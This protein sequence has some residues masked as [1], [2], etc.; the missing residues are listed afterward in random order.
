VKS[1]ARTTSKLMREPLVHFVL[2][3]AALFALDSWRGTPAVEA[4]ELR[5]SAGEID[6]LAEVFA[7][8]WMRPPTGA[9]LED[10]IREHLREEVAYREALTLG[11]DRDDTIVRRR[12]RQK[13]EFLAE[14]VAARAP[15]SEAELAAFL[16]ANPERFRL[17]PRYTF[18]HLYFS[19][20]RRVDA[21]ADARTA[22]AQLARGEVGELGDPTLLPLEFVRAPSGDV[23]RQLGDGFADGLEPLATD[24]WS[25]PLES[26]YGQHLVRLAA[27]EEG[28]LPELGEV[29][30]EVER[31][32]RAEQGARER[33]AFYAALLARYRIVIETPL[34]GEAAR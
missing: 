15:P 20:Q 7:R 4:G 24:V 10:L 23:D 27:R 8:T 32:W 2:A 5:V 34:T 9:E 30:A 1:L 6:H 18:V 11:L 31:H 3:G 26:S 28:R 29:R 22:L 33:E 16:A 12:L 21:A 14:D 13:L 17:E 25:G 19:P